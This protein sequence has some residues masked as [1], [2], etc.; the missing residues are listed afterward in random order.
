[1]LA[2]RKAITISNLLSVKEIQVYIL[3]SVSYCWG[4]G[5]GMI[6]ITKSSITSWT[7]AIPWQQLPKT[8]QD[9]IIITR[10]LGIQYLWIDALSII[11]D[12]IQY[13][14]RESANMANIFS[15]SYLTIAATAA[16]DSHVGSFLID[17][18]L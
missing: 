3:R 15:R 18:E 5:E 1:M 13:W 4:R 17:V 8:F 16:P 14:E 11:P 12:D 10:E 7:Q 6:R 9:A 2:V